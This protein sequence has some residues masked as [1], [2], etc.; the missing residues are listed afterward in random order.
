MVGTLCRGDGL[1]RDALWGDGL[2]RGRF[3]EG[4]F[5]EAP[6]APMT[7]FSQTFSYHLLTA[8]LGQLVQKQFNSFSSYF[9]MLGPTGTPLDMLSFFFTYELLRIKIG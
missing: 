6:V 8:L 5:V 3:V 7:F 2:W 4:R 9:R 1:L